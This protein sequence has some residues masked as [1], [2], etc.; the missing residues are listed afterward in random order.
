MS[1]CASAAEMPV[2]LDTGDRFLPAEDAVQ[3]AV[4]SALHGVEGSW[5]DRMSFL[6]AHALVRDN[7]RMDVVAARKRFREVEAQ[8]TN[9]VI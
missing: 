4:Q 9:G 2:E 3:R 6:R 8:T 7:Y 5:G 1:C